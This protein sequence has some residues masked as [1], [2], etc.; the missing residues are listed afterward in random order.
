M[1]P[2]KTSL[3]FDHKINWGKT[4][5]KAEYPVREKRE[6]KLFDLKTKVEEER[7]KKIDDLINNGGLSNMPG[8]PPLPGMPSLPGM[9]P[10]PGLSGMSSNNDIPRPPMPFENNKSN[11]S[12][13]DLVKRIDAKIAELEEEERKEK[14]ALAQKESKDNEKSSKEIIVEEKTVEPS[15]LNIPTEPINDLE[16]FGDTKPF[17]D[18]IVQNDIIEEKETISTNDIT[19]DQFFDDFFNDDDY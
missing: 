10:L 15:K 8:M 5:P 3:K 13:D 9:P 16:N 17:S 12:L 14:E 1:R 11:N 6:V 19:D 18:K 4:Y 2:Y 7:K